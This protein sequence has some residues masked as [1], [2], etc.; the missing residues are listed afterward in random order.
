MEAHGSSATLTVVDDQGHA[1]SRE[2]SSADD[3]GPLGEALLAKPIVEKEAPAPKEPPAKAEEKKPEAKPNPNQPEP[4]SLRDPRLL[5]SLSLGPR[6]A[7]PNHLFWGSFTVS[8]TVP[9]RPWNA[10]VWLRYDTF[11]KALEPRVPPTRE[12]CI[13]ASIARIKSSGRFEFRGALRPSL[14]V[15]TRLLTS[16]NNPSG[17]EPEPQEPEPQQFRNDTQA[18]FRIG[19]QGQFVIGLNK[20]FRAVIGLDAEGS[21]EQGFRR[22]SAHRDEGSSL[23]LPAYTVGFDLG[24]EVAVP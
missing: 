11:S 12:L 17:P 10:G 5:A 18:D 15:V 13:G 21:P 23:R 24:L 6:Y 16:N 3:I 2:V 1:I 8:A 14:A 20:R 9:F 4:P 7:G 19:L 22:L